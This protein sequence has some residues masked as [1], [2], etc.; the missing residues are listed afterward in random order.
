MLGARKMMRVTIIFVALVVMQGQVAA[1]SLP[2]I[3]ILSKPS[4][5]HMSDFEDDFIVKDKKI[6][7]NY[8]KFID[9][10][11]VNFLEAGGAKVA[12][13]DYTAS[14]H[15]L[16][17]LFKKLDGMLIPGGGASFGS[18]RHPSPFARAA[19]LMLQLS[20]EEYDNGGYFPIWGTCLGFELLL[21]IVSERPILSTKCNCKH[22]S[23]FLEF[24]NEGKFS[25]LFA[26]YTAEQ[27]YKLG[28]KSYTYN[29]HQAYVSA[30]K[31]YENEKLSNYFNILAMSKSKDGKM[32]YI[33]AIE[34]KKYPVYGVQFH[35][36]KNAYKFSPLHV[37]DHSR[38]SIEL[39]QV[40]S[41][42]FVEECRKSN[43]SFDDIEEEAKHVVY[44][45]H[46]TVNSYGYN[47]YFR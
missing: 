44:N 43:H 27:M 12:Y 25:K 26:N 32:S 16:R 7:A 14:E 37:I 4:H 33:A 34:A 46:L 40:M 10:S 24:T 28:T 9:G 42:F 6:S 30:H 18:H 35:P 15:E 45:G 22:Y 13:I 41:T 11:Y 47:Y 8:K 19:K 17:K 20:M 1:K 23:T 29:N 5:V 31:F 2:V 21:H 36:E 38:E 3:G 39:T